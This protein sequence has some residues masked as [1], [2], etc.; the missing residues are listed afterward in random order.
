MLIY[1]LLL[2]QGGKPA[3]LVGA[4]EEVTQLAVLLLTCKSLLVAPTVVLG[5]KASR[6]PITG[7][8]DTHGQVLRI[9]YQLGCGCAQTTLS[10]RGMTVTGQGSPS[11]HGTRWEGCFLGALLQLCNGTEVLAER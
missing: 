9:R 3:A 5:L 6:N 7:Q 10:Q 2:H 11:L 1:L 4:G 8:W